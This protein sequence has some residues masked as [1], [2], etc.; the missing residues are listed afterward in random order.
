MALHTAS[1]MLLLTFWCFTP[2][3]ILLCICSHFSTSSPLLPPN[4]AV[5]RDL[6][7]PCFIQSSKPTLSQYLIC[8]FSKKTLHASSFG[9][10][11]CSFV[12]TV[13]SNEFSPLSQIFNPCSLLTLYTKRLLKLLASSTRKSSTSLSTH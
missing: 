7:L 12:N 2:V 4:F 6:Y 1:I 9:T 13:Q 11:S 8:F 3:W 10:D 5:G